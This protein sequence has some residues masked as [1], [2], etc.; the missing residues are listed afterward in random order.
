MCIRDSPNSIGINGTFI[1]WNIAQISNKIPSGAKDIKLLGLL[2]E[3]NQLSILNPN[4][5]ANENNS[6]QG[7]TITHYLKLN[8]SIDLIGESQLIQSQGSVCLLYTSPSPRD[9]TRYR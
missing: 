1:D 2:S 8:G 4:E 7:L 6:G 3:S 5:T 9:R